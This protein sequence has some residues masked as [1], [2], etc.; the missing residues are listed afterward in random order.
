M[1]WYNIGIKMYAAGIQLA[2][3]IGNPKAKQWIQGRKE[4]PTNKL[5]KPCIWIHAA[6]LGEFEQA[7][8]LLETLHKKYPN[9]SIL[10]TFFSPSGYEIRKNYPLA[11]QVIYLPID[12]IANAQ[13]FIRTFQPVL[14]IF[15]KYEF[16]YNYLQILHS[17]KI[18]V[19]YVSTIFRKNQYFFQWYGKSFLSILNTVTHF[20]VQNKESVVLLHT[21]HIAQATLTGDTRLDRVLEIAN[22][23]YQNENIQKF[24]SNHFTV[25]AGSTWDK[26][27]DVL[28]KTNQ[29]LHA[30]NP[31]LTCKWILV[32]HEISTPNL[33]YIEKQFTTK[34]TIRYTAITP[35]T[36][37]EGIDVLIMD[38]M[39]MLASI[40]KYATITYVGGGF[41]KGIHNILE[42]I[43][44][45]KPVA[46]GI[47]YQKFQEAHDLIQR[48]IV[49]VITT[50]SDMLDYI[51]KHTDIQPNSTIPIQN[52]IQS[53]KGAT[54]TILYYIEANKLLP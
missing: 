54:D 40:Y 29:L 11:Q 6:S 37:F 33:L 41:G 35:T 19:L 8:P 17:H 24:V 26:D 53:N 3:L 52:Y 13:H 16:W 12:T 15:I 10:L 22:T 39:G 36:T 27:I 14:A 38:T 49:Q 9:Y 4:S 25:V 34:K 31:T 28:A 44:W 32:P 21:Q 46:F 47:R 42:P 43:A 45:H 50:P 48:N 18:P 23:K 20:F 5:T 7:R 30:D 51:T 2:A 1:F